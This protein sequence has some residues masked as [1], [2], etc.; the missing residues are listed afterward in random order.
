MGVPRSGEVN[1]LRV[2][3]WR[4]WATLVVCLPAFVVGWLV[5]ALAMLTGLAR[6][7]PSLDAELPLVLTVPW[8]AWWAK[9][10][11]YSTTISF[12]MGIHPDSGARTRKHER[13]HVRQVIDR[14]L[15]ATVLALATV[16]VDPWLALGLWVSAPLYQLPNFLG[17]LIRGD[18][19]IYRDAE[20]ERSAFAQTDEKNLG[21][22]V[23]W[24][25]DHVSKPREW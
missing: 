10:W 15:L 5:V 20:H 1:P 23:S 18:G 11:G 7:S 3:S 14:S 9:R 13:V 25:D 22:G 8:R 21:A 12:G 4:F 6:F 17:V 2:T 19:H 16:W 24:L